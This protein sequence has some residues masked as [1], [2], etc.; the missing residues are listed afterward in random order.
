MNLTKA[1][2]GFCNTSQNITERWLKE[3]KRHVGSWVRSLICS[4]SSTRSVV[5]QIHRHPFETLSCSV[6]LHKLVITF[7]PK[8]PFHISKQS[9]WANTSRFQNLIPATVKGQYSTGLKKYMKISEVELSPWKWTLYIHSL[10][11]HKDGNTICC[12]PRV[13][14]S[15]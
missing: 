7:I 3:S 4:N 8:H 13:V 12:V 6:W 10:F 11:F 15:K 9:W 2:V 14:I 5:L 1:I